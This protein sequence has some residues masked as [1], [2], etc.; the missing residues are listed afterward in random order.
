MKKILVCGH[1]GFALKYPQN[2]LPSFEGAIAAGCDRIEYDL[3]WTAD[4]RLVVCHNPT[5]D[6]TSNGTGK[7]AE[8]T[9]DEIRKLDF[10]SWKDA[11]FAGT[12]I[13]E[14][15]EVLELTN[16]LN[17]KLFHLVE[18]KVNSLDYAEHV[19]RELFRYGMAGRFIL[20]SFHLDLLREIKKRHPD[21]LVH[22]N[23]N[24]SLKEFDYEDYRIFDWVGIRRDNVTAAIVAGFHSV[25]TPVD[26]WPVDTV[27]EFRLQ[28]ANDVDSV[29]SND[30][31]TVIA[32]RDKG[33]I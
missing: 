12:P 22:G 10:G 17:P 11:R 24:T 16:R 7:I 33:S 19:I 4:R 21:V 32:E 1:R 26:A 23:P 3:H 14:F 27:E 15:R 29:T 20:V 6:S 25:G 13:P 30:P 2:T 9:F 5:V 28:A 8:M 18:L 31:E